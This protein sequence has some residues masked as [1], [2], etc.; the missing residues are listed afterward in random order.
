MEAKQVTRAIGRATQFSN[1]FVWLDLPKSMGS[2]TVADVVK[3]KTLRE[4]E[5]LGRDWAVSAWE[6]WS[7]HHAQIRK[8]SQL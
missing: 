4:Y 7:I 3:T 6:A 1:Q 5:S 8:W 2:I